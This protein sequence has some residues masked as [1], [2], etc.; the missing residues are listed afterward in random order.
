MQSDEWKVNAIIRKLFF[1]IR[2]YLNGLKVVNS[3]QD[4]RM[5]KPTGKMMKIKGRKTKGGMYYMNHKSI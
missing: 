5:A 2:M 1:H 4:R 3:L